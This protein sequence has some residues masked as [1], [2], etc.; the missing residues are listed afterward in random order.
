MRTTILVLLAL[1]AACSK[2]DAAA[3]GGATVPPVVGAQ[4]A[5][6]TAQKYFETVDA[7]GVVTARA[8][9]VAALA[10]PAPTRVAKVF[11]T[12]GERVRIGDP[13]VAFESAPFDAAAR[14]AE[15]AL[16]AAERGAERAQRL[17]A[18]GVLPRKDADAA[19]TD[20]A[21]A[22]ANAVTARRF[23]ELATLRAPIA[24]VVT[25]MSAVLGA[26]ADPSQPMVEV[27]D[28]SMLDVLL[29]LSPIDAMRVHAGQRVALYVGAQA[30]GDPIAKGTVEDVAGAVDTTSR[31]VGTRV[32]VSPAAPALRLGQTLFGR[33]AVAEHPDAV[34]VP[35]EALVPADEGFRVFVVDSAG[36]AHA[37]P[38]V[39][40]A[41][42]D[43]L[44]WIKQGVKAGERVVTHG[45]YGVDDSVKVMTGKP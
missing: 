40:G 2:P 13:L 37:T 24:G 19:N 5:T 21:V 7:V 12:V 3:D 9:H 29:T 41:R 30:S 25:R 33:I 15:M 4:V 23:R 17:A 38:V 16:T 6:A 39:L 34:M 44:A 18:A 45:A 31:G 20:L 32:A 27:A 36:I 10:A 14:S 28:P 35:I 26:N 1:G 8:G 43:K 11:V 22:R 42:G